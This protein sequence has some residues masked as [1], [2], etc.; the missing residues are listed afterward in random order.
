MVATQPSINEILA[1]IG[2]QHP[3]IDDDTH[4]PPSR[5]SVAYFLRYANGNS[6][7]FP[8]D[9]LDSDDRPARPYTD[10]DMDDAP[11]G[12][13]RAAYLAWLYR[14]EQAESWIRDNTTVYG[15]PVADTDA[16]EKMQAAHVAYQADL[17]KQLGEA[18]QP[19]QVIISPATVDW[20]WLKYSLLQWRGTFYRPHPLTQVPYAVFE[21]I[22]YWYLLP[23]PYPPLDDNDKTLLH[24]TT[25][26]IPNVFTN[27]MGEM[28]T[29]MPVF[30]LMRSIHGKA[31]W[32]QGEN[33]MLYQDWEQNKSLITT[34]LWPPR[35]VKFPDK[36][37]DASD[38]TEAEAKYIHAMVT[39]SARMGGLSA[40]HGD[41]LTACIM[42][43]LKHQLS[44]GTTW[45]D[46]DTILN[47]RGTKPIRK[48]ERGVT[49]DAGH[50]TDDRQIIADIMDHLDHFW[51]QMSNVPLQESTGGGPGHRTRKGI[52][53]TEC[54]ALIIE[55]RQT[56]HTFGADGNPRSLT[57][58]WRF[59]V[60]RWLTP[61][62]TPRQQTSVI[63]Q[64]VLA[65]D[66]SQQDWEKIVGHYILW[67]FR[68]DAKIGR[69]RPK[70]VRIGTMF[71]QCSLPRNERYPRKTIDR[72]EKMLAQLNRDADVCASIMYAP[73][74]KAVLDAL[75][76]KQLLDHWM[77]L[78]VVITPCGETAQRNALIAKQADVLSGRET[79]R[80][81]KGGKNR[82]QSV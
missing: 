13:R 70:T 12:S 51:V 72:F 60:G 47:Y 77:D 52:I 79:K 17:A 45:I 71:E 19:G 30:G 62:L 20:W 56:Q 32:R 43:V 18:V 23:P 5:P 25:P 16:Y 73:K 3:M 49:R 36:M 27:G 33:G 61:F 58:A 28:S 24:P 1:R 76:R 80:N 41:V 38:I 69:G 8:A 2:R 26:Y 65:Y 81:A 57:I 14:R 6:G 55:E 37:P 35:I 66:S 42:Q 46:S 22:Q 63:P 78:M 34:S 82:G 40:A 11:A 9:P 50:R 68:S 39:N 54:K 15:T 53:T 21:Q 67:L 4:T 64:S 31:N 29:A 75:P 59:R 74:S 10:A 48:T 7:D 44:D